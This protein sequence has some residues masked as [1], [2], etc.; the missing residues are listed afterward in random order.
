MMTNVMGTISGLASTATCPV[1]A[2]SVGSSAVKT[3]T[4]TDFKPSCGVLKNGDTVD[5]LGQLVSGTLMAT[6]VQR[7]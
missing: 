6:R 2:F 1:I 4:T 3:Q 5:V 7:R